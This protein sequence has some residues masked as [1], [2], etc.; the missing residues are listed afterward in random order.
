MF[1]SILSGCGPAVDPPSGDGDTDGASSSEG[2]DVSTGST[3]GTA[4]TLPTSATTTSGTT[5]AAGF[6]D[7]NKSERA[8]FPTV[9][10]YLES[11]ESIDLTCEGTNSETGYPGP[12]SDGD[13]DDSGSGSSGGAGS[14]SGTRSDGGGSTSAGIGWDDVDLICDDL[15]AAVLC[16]VSDSEAGGEPLQGACEFSELDAEGGVAMTCCYSVFEMGGRGHACIEPMRRGQPDQDLADVLAHAYFS[17]AASVLAFDRLAQE[18]GELGCPEPMLRRVRDA[19]EDEARHARIVRSLCE[20]HARLPAEPRE[21]PVALRSMLEIAIENAVEGCVRETAAALIAFHQSE[22]AADPSVAAAM[23]SIA[24]DELR[25]AALAWDLH[26]WLM[27]KLSPAEGTRVRE[28]L[29]ESVDTLLKR[30]QA[31]HPRAICRALGL[32]SPAHRDQMLG[33]LSTGLWKAGPEA[34]SVFLSV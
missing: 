13:G 32:P 19:S 17:E 24:P 29:E 28:A 12:D 26:D 25:H 5:P 4:T 21:R 31:P 22:R 14:S 7:S 27:S 33:Q 9:D 10:S 11:R 6:C 34:E 1:A 2:N 23:R 8:Y 15:C 16:N 18:L 30:T 20:Q 3:S